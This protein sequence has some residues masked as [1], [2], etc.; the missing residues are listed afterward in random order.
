MLV[1]IDLILKWKGTT[2][3]E[4]QKAKR[5]W[6]PGVLFA[7][8]LCIVIGFWGYVFV[9]G[10]RD[11]AAG[12]SS[13]AA[14]GEAFGM[15]S[16]LFTGLALIA[17]GV[18]AYFQWVS[19][20]EERSKA[21]ADAVESRFFQLL[22]SLQTAVNETRVDRLIGRQAIRKISEYLLEEHE[23][24]Q[25]NLSPGSANM[26]LEERRKDISRW[27]KQF[28]DGD[29]DEGKEIEVRYGDLIGHLFRLTYHILRYID[30]S[31]AIDASEKQ[32]YARILRAH[33][34]NPELVLLFYNC[35]SEYGY[36]KHH[37][38]VDKYNML[39]NM[40]RSPLVGQYDVLLYKSLAHTAPPA[41]PVTSEN[42]A[43]H[44]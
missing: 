43:S 2:V 6:L 10:R 24:E 42:I 38:L 35:L 8:A 7:L 9:S 4:V 16:A 19:M 13:R 26:S 17:A 34:S 27:Y 20:R 23:D 36:D 12:G 32:F 40:N 1:L 44:S 39:K 33:L 31:T 14:V 22:A 21:A 37:P 41:R 15:A 30:E 3:T 28:V 18:A 29:T 5:S 11:W 25:R